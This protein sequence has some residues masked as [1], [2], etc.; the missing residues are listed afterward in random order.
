MVDEYHHVPAVSFERVLAEVRALYVTGLTATP[1]RRDGQHPII[2]MQLGP[3][4]HVASRTSSATVRPFRHRLIV[5]ETAFEFS[6]PQPLSGDFRAVYDARTGGDQVFMVD[7]S[8]VAAAGFTYA[9][10]LR[11]VTDNVQVYLISTNTS[12]DVVGAPRLDPASGERPR[13]RRTD[14]RRLR[15]APIRCCASARK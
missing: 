2:E 11:G 12:A 6:A 15:R 9:L 7:M 5:R 13:L 10:D 1:T 4:R 8:T 3:A 14:R